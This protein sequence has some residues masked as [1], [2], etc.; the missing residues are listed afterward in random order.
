M[1]T[2]KNRTQVLREGQTTIITL[3]RQSSVQ[4]VSI[5]RKASLRRFSEVTR[6]SIKRTHVHRLTGLLC[7]IRKAAVCVVNIRNHEILE[8]IEVCVLP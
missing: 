6:G 2:R 3:L 5:Y 1:A 4:P 7:L 8:G